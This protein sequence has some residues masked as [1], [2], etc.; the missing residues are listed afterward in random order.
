MEKTIDV[1][2][3]GDICVDMIL[4]GKDVVPEFGQTEKLIDGYSLE[5]GGSCCIFASQT[6]K[7][8]LKTTLVG[9]VGRDQFGE[10]VMSTL[11]EAG[12][13]TENVIVT[14]KEKTGISVALNKGYDRA[15]LTYNGT[16]DA[17]YAQDINEE[18]LK[19]TRHLHIGSYFLMKKLQPYYPEI[20]RKLKGY[21]ATISLDTNWDP[22]NK[23]ESGLWDI[24]PLVDMVFLNENEALGISKC[25]NLSA[26]VE[27]LRKHVPIVVIKRGEDGAQLFSDEGFYSSNAIKGSVADTVGAGDSFDG[28]FV[29]GFLTGRT[30]KEC[31]DIGCICGSLNTRQNGGVK[32]QPL[33]KELMQF[34]THGI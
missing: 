5:L 9:K 23:W 27:K 29:Y 22:D 32:G 1:L 24:I 8:G 2:T 10:F 18:L 30:K 19:R 16:I 4:S 13:D 6:A 28:G 21:G 14:E 12:I 26:A 25:D 34:T 15:I 7:L 31:M 3:F 11:R 17:L 20:I 33:L